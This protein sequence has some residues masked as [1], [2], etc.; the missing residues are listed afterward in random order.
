MVCCC[1]F[2]NF[3]EIFHMKDLA[4]AE[5]SYCGKKNIQYWYISCLY[6]R[7]AHEESDYKD[8]HKL[9]KYDNSKLER[10]EHFIVEG[11]H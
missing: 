6:Y 5:V 3:S 4:L 11:N 2:Y 8:D 10:K 1:I 7:V 9:F